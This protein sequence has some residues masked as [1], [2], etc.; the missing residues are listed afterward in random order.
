MAEE[1]VVTPEQET[2]AREFGWKPKEEFTG[3]EAQ[4]RPADEFLRRGQEVNGFLRKD[5]QKIRDKN[6]GLENELRSVREAVGEF[7]KFHEQTEERSYKKALADLQQ[8]KKVAITDGDG[9]QVIEIENK[10]EELKEARTPAKAEVKDTAVQDE[11]YRQQFV[12]WTGENEWFQNDSALRAAS[13]G[14]ADEVRA[15]NPTMVGKEFLNEVAKKVKKGFPEKFENQNRDRVSAVEGNTGTQRSKG[16][17][18]AYAD[19]PQDAKQAC[20][21]F[22]KQGLVTQAQYLADYFEE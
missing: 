1:N 2:Q 11:I 14:F 16:N 19:L 15:E 3:D 4:W 20:D 8:E 17:K 18:K 22:V 12:E 13:S 7:K 21:R 5:L 6:L 10:I 9:S